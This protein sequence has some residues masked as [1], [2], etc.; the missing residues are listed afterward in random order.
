LE[1]SAMAMSTGSKTSAGMVVSTGAPRLICR[2]LA[3]II[4]AFS[5]LV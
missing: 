2:A 1:Y 3:P 4:R 5:N